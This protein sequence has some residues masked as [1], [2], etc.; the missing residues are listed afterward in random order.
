MQLGNSHSR[1][2]PHLN[3]TRVIPNQRTPVQ[4]GYSD[5]GLKAE[6]EIF[7]SKK[8][9]I[10]GE[11]LP[12]EIM[13]SDKLCSVTECSSRSILRPA[14]LTAASVTWTTNDYF[15]LSLTSTINPTPETSSLL[16]GI[17]HRASDRQRID[18]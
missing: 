3:L 17:Q 12:S 16:P 10:F 18:E 9:I 7:E 14:R 1:L 13:P 4:I 8:N 2:C 5:G 11:L 6:D 15:D